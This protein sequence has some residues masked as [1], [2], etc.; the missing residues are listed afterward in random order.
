MRQH[1]RMPMRHAFG[2]V[3]VPL[4]AL[5]LVACATLLS[6]VPTQGRTS[7]NL[8]QRYEIVATLDLEAGTLDS[9]LTLS[10]TNRASVTID[11]L[12][13]SVIPRALGYLTMEGPITADDERVTTA[14]TTSTNLRV[15]LAEPLASRATVVLRVPFHLTI[16]TSAAP[17]T[18]R[19]SRENGVVSLGEWF[20]ILSRE[21]D[22]YGVGDPQISFSADLIRVDLTTTTSLPRDAVACPG[23]VS[24]PDTSG[25]SWRC[26]AE[27]VRDF[28]LVVNPAFRL[29]TRTVGD[30]ALRVY[31]ETVPGDVTADKA[32]TALIGME[33][34]FGDYPWPDLVLAEIGGGGGFSM[35]YP[36]AIHLTRTKVTDSYVI[37]HE[38]AHQWFYAQVGNDQQREPWLDE[39]FADFSARYLLGIG[40]NQC[41]SRDVDSSVFEWPAGP[42]SGGDWTSCD[43]YFHAVFD[44]GTE[45]LNAVRAAMGDEAFFGA[46]REYIEL[47]RHDVVTGR[48]LLDH[49]QRRTE[50]DLLPLYRLYLRAYD[51]AAPLPAPERPTAGRHPGRR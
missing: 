2:P 22:V 11:H 16:G 12:N 47:H 4:A 45:F 23:L 7:T 38:V 37:F 31:T 28:S 36:R 32:L 49:L 17:F 34:A 14:W 40:E 8:G 46:L 9:V 15:D 21:H 24:A 13:L 42:I 44:K 43:G 29:T 30:T 41:S 25:T 10:L 20:P 35:E 50:A 27:D 1:G 5:A 51:A 3:R 48:G 19:L 39:G 33:E 6:A 18:A 26:E